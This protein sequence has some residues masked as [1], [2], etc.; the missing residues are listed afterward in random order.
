MS[1]PMD[2]DEVC[3]VQVN[4]GEDPSI[5]FDVLDVAP[6]LVGQAVEAEDDVNDDQMSV[7]K[8][9]SGIE[10]QKSQK[11]AAK[12]RFFNQLLENI[13]SSIKCESDINDT[14]VVCG[15]ETRCRRFRI[16]SLLMASICPV[17]RSVEATNDV[18]QHFVILPDLDGGDFE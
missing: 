13:L 18:D 15:C 1:T 11:S 2:D 14:V 16:P 3:A 17:F 5:V 12:N 8:F 6:H 7:D 10:F 9:E 4:V